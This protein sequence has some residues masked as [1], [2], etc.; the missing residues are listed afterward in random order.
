M[1]LRIRSM[2]KAANLS[3]EEFATLV[4]VSSRT[5]GSWER[6]ESVPNAEQIW[7]CA[8]IFNTDPNTLMGWSDEEA[9]SHLDSFEHELIECYRESTSEG[10]VVILGNARGQRELALKTAEGPSSEPEDMM[11][12]GSM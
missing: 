7:R 6:N 11:A 12:T 3:Q 5:V 9:G 2:R 8:E 4:P 1:N 10:R